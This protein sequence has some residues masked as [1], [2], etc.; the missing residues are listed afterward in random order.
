MLPLNKIKK[1][2]RHDRS[3]DRDG[4]DEHPADNQPTFGVGFDDEL[5]HTI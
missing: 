4:G 5:T 3:R 2:E 1:P